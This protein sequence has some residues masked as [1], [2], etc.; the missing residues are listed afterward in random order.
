[1]FC[2]S[3][4]IQLNKNLYNTEIKTEMIKEF[5]EN[6]KYESPQITK[7]NIS[8]NLI[9]K[10]NKTIPINTDHQTELVKRFSQDLKGEYCYGDREENTE[11]LRKN[12][13]RR[14][15]ISSCKPLQRAYNENKKF[16]QIYKD[17]MDKN[18]SLNNHFS[19]KNFRANSRE[20]DKSKESNKKDEIAKSIKITYIG[21]ANNQSMTNINNNKKGLFITEKIDEK[22]KTNSNFFQ[23]DNKIIEIYNKI[24]ENNLDEAE[25]YN[26]V[27]FVALKSVKRNPT[28]DIRNTS[29]PQKKEDYLELKILNKDN[30]EKRKTALNFVANKGLKKG[31]LNKNL[32]KKNLNHLDYDKLNSIVKGFG[33]SKAFLEKCKF[34]QKDAHVERLEMIKRYQER[35]F[36]NGNTSKEKLMKIKE[37]RGKKP[38]LNFF[39]SNSNYLDSTPL[40]TDAWHATL[41]DITEANSSKINKSKE[42]DNQMRKALKNTFFITCKKE[43]FLIYKKREIPKNNYLF[44]LNKKKDNSIKSIGRKSET[45]KNIPPVFKNNI[46]DERKKKNTIKKHTALRKKNKLKDEN[47][48]CNGYTD[49][50]NIYKLTDKSIEGRVQGNY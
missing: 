45:D 23:S 48:Q 43:P 30:L 4:P 26:S 41:N 3:K 2:E 18:F 39:I 19:E 6:I 33:N 31:V 14:K 20:R 36:K 22:A 47:I 25:K 13:V 35:I 24:F 17:K 42:N 10:E 49:D 50:N 37:V 11:I 1:M 44:D 21:G 5:Y 32:N 29:L 12:Q 38:E 8:T 40:S 16:I 9:S 28:P 15:F 46:F 27:R 34:D 7:N